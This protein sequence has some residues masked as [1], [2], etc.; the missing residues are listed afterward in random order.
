[1]LVPPT[2]PETAPCLYQYSVNIGVQ[3]LV[4]KKRARSLVVVAVAVVI[5]VAD[6]AVAVA[7]AVAVV[8]AVAVAVAVVVAVAGVVV[9]GGGVAPLAN[10]CSEQ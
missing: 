10:A 1:M 4:G 2:Q 3:R 7:V 5:A 9:S 6:V 8:V